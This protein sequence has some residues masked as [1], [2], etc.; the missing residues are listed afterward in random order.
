L[1]EVH[2]ATYEVGLHCAKGSTKG[3]FKKSSPSLSSIFRKWSQNNY[4]GS[5][6]LDTTDKD[7]SP[8]KLESQTPSPDEC[9]AAP[10][11]AFK[12][13]GLLDRFLALWILLAIVIGI[14]LGNFVPNT[15]PIAEGKICRGLRAYR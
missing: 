14:I 12:G 3:C 13:L 2:L 15:S 4:S 9:I 1:R 11:S 8:E 6:S 5:E 7:K 10:T